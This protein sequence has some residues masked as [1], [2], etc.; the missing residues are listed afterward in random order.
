VKLDGDDVTEPEVCRGG[1]MMFSGPALI[2]ERG[3][4]TIRCWL[5]P[6]S[7]FDWTFLGPD[8]AGEAQAFR[9]GIVMAVTI[10]A[11]KSLDSFCIECPECCAWRWYRAEWWADLG[12][13]EKGSEAPL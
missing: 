4:V 9:I 13:R 2:P 6:G 8:V 7:I 5:V 3:T 1:L 12:G 10:P 11:L